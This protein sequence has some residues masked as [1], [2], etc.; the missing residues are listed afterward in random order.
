MATL[1]NVNGL[2]PQ[3]VRPNPRDSPSSRPRPPPRPTPSHARRKRRYRA[4]STVA[5]RS[6]R[7]FDPD[8][9]RQARRLDLDRSPR[10]IVLPSSSGS[11]AG[12]A[13]RGERAIRAGRR[14]LRAGHQDDEQHR[15]AVLQS[16]RPADGA[17]PRDARA[18]RRLREERRAGVGEGGAGEGPGAVQASRRPSGH[19]PVHESRPQR[20]DG[21]LAHGA[22]RDSSNR[23]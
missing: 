13:V 3:Q 10:S 12:H 17:R 15:P 9:T 14:R 8:P 5:A 18:V 21:R 11:R 6:L 7:F 23:G 16:R 20:A 22:R 4:L 2:N 1:E 19:A